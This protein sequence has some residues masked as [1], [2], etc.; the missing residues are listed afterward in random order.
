M[1]N[2]R[3][4]ARLSAGQHTLECPPPKETSNDEASDRFFC[5]ERSFGAMIVGCED[6]GTQPQVTPAAHISGTVFALDSSLPVEAKVALVDGRRFTVVAGPVTTDANGRYELSR[7]P[8]ETFY[9]FVFTDEHLAL[10]PSSVW[11]TLTA[12]EKLER[13]IG[14]IPAELEGK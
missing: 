4:S 9:L 6:S 13:N 1:A 3:A 7:L 5:V 2:V 14:L 10:E 12:G 11:V 8:T